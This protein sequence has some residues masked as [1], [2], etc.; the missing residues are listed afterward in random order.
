MRSSPQNIFPKG[1]SN[2]RDLEESEGRKMQ[3]MP[4]VFAGHGSPMNVIEDNRFVQGWRRMAASLPTPEAILAVS[5]HWYTAGT[6]VMANRNPRTIHDFF[7]FPEELYKIVY[8]A[9]GAPELAAQAR[10]LLGEAAAL[11][12]GWGLDH[13]TWSV[14]R[15]MYPDADIPV[16]QVSVNSRAPAAVHF[17]LGE[18]L[19]ELRSQGV[20]IFG[21]GN[22]VHNLGM[23]DF[24]R[25]GGFDWAG[26]FDDY[27]AACI[28]AGNTEGLIG[29][30]EAGWSAGLAV[31][32]PDHY[33]P[34]LYVLGAREA[35]DRPQV[36]NRECVLGS[37]SMTSYVFAR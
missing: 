1:L 32:T 28:E 31:P 7:G 19:R 21:S 14:L 36:Y 20:M 2:G 30:E 8:P 25:S 35:D 16:F 12:S 27:V 24:A 11:D 13:G 23:I 6:K 15:A 4:A 34:L 3:A 37:I 22:V 18:R 33:L 5:A 10:D 9:P 17:A 29:Y 26:D